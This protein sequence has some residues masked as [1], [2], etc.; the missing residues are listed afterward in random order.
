MIKTT[1]LMGIAALVVVAIAHFGLRRR[2]GQTATGIVPTGT[3]ADF[4]DRPVSFSLVLFVGDHL[5]AVPELLAKC[6]YQLLEQTTVTASPS[7]IYSDL[8]DPSG[9]QNT[10]V[11]KAA[12]SHDGFTVLMEP[13]MVLLTEPEPLIQ[14]CVNRHTRLVCVLWERVTETAGLVE[15]TESGVSR[16]AWYLA[17]SASQPPKNPPQ[18]LTSR[19]DATGLSNSLVDL[20]FPKALLTDEVSAA[21]F[22]LKE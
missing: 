16:E 18:A 15:V 8:P 6:G 2:R 3:P 4:W 10:I 1:I 14:F 5:G 11:F 22:K 13:E 17:G 20:G 12:Y 21:R 9:P 19:P 7:E